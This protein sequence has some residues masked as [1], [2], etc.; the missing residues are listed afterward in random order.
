[1]L[2]GVAV[3]QRLV[4]EHLSENAPH[5]PHVYGL[6]VVLYSEHNLRSMIPMRHGVPVVLRVH[7]PIIS[8]K[9]LVNTHDGMDFKM[10]RMDLR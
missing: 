3:E 5:T 6:G 9:S 10:K 4:S 7:E 8:C 1:M 2:T